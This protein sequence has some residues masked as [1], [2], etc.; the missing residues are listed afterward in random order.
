MKGQASEGQTSDDKGVGGAGGA[1]EEKQERVTEKAGDGKTSLGEG[2]QG[3]TSDDKGVG[4]AGGAGEEKQVR[5][6]KNEIQ[7]MSTM[8]NTMRQ[9]ASD[10]ERFIS[11]AVSQV[12]HSIVAS[13][14]SEDYCQCFKI[15]LC[16]TCFKRLNHL[17]TT[18]P[19]NLSFCLR[20]RQNVVMVLVI[21]EGDGE[22]LQWVIDHFGFAIDIG[23]LYVATANLEYRHASVR[24]N[25]AHKIGQDLADVLVNWDCSRIMGSE[26]LPML[27]RLPFF[28]PLKFVAGS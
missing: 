27:L 4:G 21:H 12:Q 13:S 14:T 28:D 3:K 22:T 18:L 1:G 15:A 25:T 5:V 7:R 2:E 9:A 6:T 26:F 23:L 17:R 11:G 24:K 19:V 16:S 10:A 20:F 8:T